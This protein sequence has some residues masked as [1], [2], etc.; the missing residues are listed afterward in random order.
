M[1]RRGDPLAQNGTRFGLARGIAQ[2]RGDIAH[3]RGILLPDLD[4][5]TH[6]S[7]PLAAPASKPKNRFGKADS[8]NVL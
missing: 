7:P 6:E 4:F 1:A 3:E 5:E 8:L 2:C